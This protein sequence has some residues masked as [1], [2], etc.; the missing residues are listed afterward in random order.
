MLGIDKCS[1]IELLFQP[2]EE[3]LKKKKMVGDKRTFSN[4]L[5]IPNREINAEEK[6]KYQNAQN[7]FF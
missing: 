7:Y 1:T 5:R 6:G 2:K 3:Y 4:R